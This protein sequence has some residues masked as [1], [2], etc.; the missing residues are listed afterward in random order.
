MIDF[1]MKLE[2]IL[3]QSEY[4][5]WE[6]QYDPTECDWILKLDGDAVVMRKFT[7]KENN[8]GS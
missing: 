8:N 3:M 6:I 2:N 7:G 4:E 1:I 5:N